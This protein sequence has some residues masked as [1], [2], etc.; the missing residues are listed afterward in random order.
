MIICNSSCPFLPF[1]EAVIRPLGLPAKTTVAM[2]HS[3]AFF[4]PPGIL[5]IYSG[6]QIIIP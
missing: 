3:M 4:S 2:Q 5:K 6:V 1:A